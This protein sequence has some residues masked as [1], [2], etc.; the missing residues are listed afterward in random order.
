MEGKVDV[1]CGNLGA[2]NVEF[3]DEKLVLGEDLAGFGND[4]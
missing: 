4:F 1:I 3:F 2:E